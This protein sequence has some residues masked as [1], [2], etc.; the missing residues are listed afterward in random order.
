MATC[1]GWWLHNKNIPPP[2]KMA[3]NAMV[4]IKTRFIRTQTHTNWQRIW[5]RGR[6]VHN[7]YNNKYRTVEA[8]EEARSIT[9][10]GRRETSKA[11]VTTT[12]RPASKKR[13]GR[14]LLSFRVPRGLLVLSAA[15]VKAH[16][17]T[18][19]TDRGRGRHSLCWGRAPRGGGEGAAKHKI[20]ER[21]LSQQLQHSIK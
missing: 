3:C 6:S 4:E 20:R 21:S 13:F 1:T 19:H 7:Y 2:S 11:S 12:T 16:T 8:C 14:R 10:G 9:S 18:V 15:K 5:S 17:H